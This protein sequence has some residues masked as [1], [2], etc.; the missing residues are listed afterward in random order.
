MGTFL[1]TRRTLLI[2]MSAAG[3]SACSRD[4]SRLSRADH[5]YVMK[6]ERRMFLL[7]GNEQLAGFRVGLGFQPDGHKEAEGDGRTPE[8]LYFID[9]KNPRSDFYLSL[10]INYPNAADIARSEAMGVD[11]GG[12]IFIHGESDNRY[13]PDS[14][15]WTAGCIAVSNREIEEIY[16]RVP[17]GTPVTIR[18]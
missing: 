16:S 15:D 4:Y 8:G 2:G 10:G 13:N 12:D 3:L 1:T 7:R 14:P 6:A 11:P 18:A 5:V 17:V 9:R